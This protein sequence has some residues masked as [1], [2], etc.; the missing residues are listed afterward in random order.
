VSHLALLRGHTRLQIVSGRRSPPACRGSAGEKHPEEGGLL[1]PGIKKKVAYKLRSAAA[2]EAR[3]N[4]RAKNG[5]P[6][7]PVVEK[8]PTP[9]RA[10]RPTVLPQ[11]AVVSETIQRS[12][13]KMSAQDGHAVHST[14][15]PFNSFLRSGVLGPNHKLFTADNLLDDVPGILFDSP[16][17]RGCLSG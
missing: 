12:D 8:V 17:T 3:V 4:E 9:E 5:L 1:Y 11:E 2:D 6:P 10:T 16:T 14:S 7:L 15:S 13:K